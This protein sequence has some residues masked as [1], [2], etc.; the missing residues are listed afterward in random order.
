M[1]KL[2]SIIIPTYWKFDTL[3]KECTD[4]IIKNTTKEMLDQMEIIMVANGSPD[5]TDIKVE[6]LTKTNLNLFRSIISKEQLGFVKASNAGAKIAVGKYMLFVNDDVVFLDWQTPNEWI[7]RMM[8]PF[9]ENPKMGATG[10][11]AL[12]DGWSGHRFI[13][14]FC[15]LTPSELFRKHGYFD[16]I[17][18]PA[19]G[20]DVNYCT[21]LQVEDGLE[22]LQTANTV[23]NG[24]TNASDFPIWHKDNKSYGTIAEYRDVICPRNGLIN[25]QRWNKHA[26]INLGSGGSLIREY[27]NVD[28]HD[29]RAQLFYDIEKPM[30]EFPD[31]CADEIVAS[32]VFEHL[33][34][35]T[36]VDTLKEWLRILNSGG[37]LVME[38]PHIVKQ[39]Q[40]LVDSATIPEK[41][42]DFYDNIAMIYGTIN[43]F[44][45]PG[46]SSPHLYGWCEETVK[47]QLERAGY[48]DIIFPNHTEW[49]HPGPNFRV[50]AKKP[51]DKI[52][53]EQTSEI[54]LSG[55]LDS[56]T[57]TAAIPTKGRYH[58][59]L[60]QCIISVLNQTRLP[61]KLVIF[62]DG[63]QKD[64]RQDAFYY[65]IFKLIEEKGI[66]WSVVFGRK[67]G[68]ADIDQV[69][70]EKCD[71]SWIWRL[72]DDNVADSNVLARLL[73]VA[74]KDEK[75]GALA[76][77]AIMVNGHNKVWHKIS[78]GVIQDIYFS[79]NVQWDKFDGIRETDHLHNTFL[80]RRKL[81]SHGYNTNLSPVG[82]REETMFTYGIKKQGYKLVVVGD[83]VTWHM[84]QDDGG[85]RSYEVEQNMKKDEAIFT[86]LM[87]ADGIQ[88]RE[89][90][91]I[92]LDNGI[93]DHYAFKNILLEL[94]KKYGR[95]ILATCYPDV[96]H[97]CPDIIQISIQD[98]KDLGHN[99]VDYSVYEWMVKNNWNKSIV[100]A[101][102]KM[103]L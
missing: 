93:G 38:M 84:K 98:I 72:D 52:K 23:Y 50:E 19:G 6:E 81:A 18:V 66:Q 99:M 49:L 26:K 56:W 27:V 40:W 78:S 76:S 65:N 13:V 44:N 20:E 54:Q 4:S 103:Y 89:T 79:P 85:I 61:E 41:K 43:T 82:H 102:R 47:E 9:L 62:D 25:L 74:K 10:P 17:Y 39:C 35:Y 69:I 45:E 80:Y 32:H 75:I 29:K 64:L 86:A 53:I 92:A 14:G 30:P 73:D 70:I 34:P 31:N 7:D 33:N 68:M 59:T 46:K 91:I 5:G 77:C 37:R 12:F 24:S 2:V 97:D 57:V 87:K 88:F 55:D 48:T 22:V 36:V 60:P 95:I 28:L 100:E 1:D 16:E 67:K 21:A 71:T 94:R 58:T 63:E 101:F 8:K 3:I 83:V 11:L 90:K 15:L 96:F 42:K 51:G